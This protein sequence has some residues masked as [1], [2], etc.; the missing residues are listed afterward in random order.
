MVDPSDNPGPYSPDTGA[1]YEEKEV[2]HQTGLE[3]DHT[4]DGL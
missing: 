3:V 1:P 4:Q 2:N